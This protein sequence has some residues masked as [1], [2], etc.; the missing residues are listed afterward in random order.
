MGGSQRD[1]EPGPGRTWLGFLGAG[2]PGRRA[3]AQ[4]NRDPNTHPRLP[5]GNRD[6]KGGKHVSPATLGSS[7]GYRA[8]ALAAPALLFPEGGN[9]SET[10]VSSP[11]R[12]S[13]A[14]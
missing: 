12:R 1:P 11:D 9:T 10:S 13:L 6:P 14:D 2:E 5:K 4:P 8:A 3:A 7:P